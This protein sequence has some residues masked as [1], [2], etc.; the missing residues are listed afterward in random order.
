MS[1][2]TKEVGDKRGGRGRGWGG[3]SQGDCKGTDLGLLEEGLQGG[4]ADH[5]SGLGNGRPD[6]ADSHSDQQKQRRLH[7]L[8]IGWGQRSNKS[9]GQGEG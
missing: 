1:R 4:V 7:H 5:A 8:G 2:A 3:S 9:E 6:R